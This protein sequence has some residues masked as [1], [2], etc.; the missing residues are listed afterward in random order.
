MAQWRDNLALGDPEIGFSD[1]KAVAP[2]LY[3][4]KRRIRE[5][6]LLG[7]KVFLVSWLRRS[8]LSFLHGVLNFIF[9]D[10]AVGVELESKVIPF[11]GGYNE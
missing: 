1:Y 7:G 6:R 3:P 5:R 11:L 10:C 9:A 4:P 2:L 8:D